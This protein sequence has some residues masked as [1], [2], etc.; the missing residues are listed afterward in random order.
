MSQKLL[1]VIFADAM[2]NRCCATI[3]LDGQHEIDL[4]I[5]RIASVQ[6]P[7]CL[8]NLQPIEGP[9]L[10]V[11]CNHDITIIGAFAFF[12]LCFHLGNDPLSLLAVPQ[13]LRELASFPRF[14][15]HELAEAR[16][17]RGIEVKILGNIESFR[18]RLLDHAD[19]PFCL[20][21]IDA[22]A[23]ELDVRNLGTNLCFARDAEQFAERGFDFGTFAP[24][25][26]GINSVIA[27]CDFRQF[28]DLFG[29]CKGTGQVNKSG[30]EPECAFFHGLSDHSFH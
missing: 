2:K 20:A 16:A 13:T 28:D 15:R 22:T 3:G 23:R 29:L 5:E 8:R 12:E 24:H 30:G 11:I 25:M 10:L 18:T 7:C 1:E 17:R 21:P 4:R 19:D 6:F 14:F 9:V 26:A 27:R